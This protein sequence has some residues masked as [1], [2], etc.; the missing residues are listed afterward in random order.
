MQ[1]ADWVR[2]PSRLQCHDGTDTCIE[3]FRSIRA[4]RHAINYQVIHTGTSSSQQIPPK[5]FKRAVPP[6]ITSD[7]PRSHVASRQE[8]ASFFHPLIVM[9]GAPTPTHP[10]SC[11][12]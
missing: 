10:G 7:A 11:A 4:L 6:E 3:V 1:S 9:C 8:R 5:P 2:V 12:G